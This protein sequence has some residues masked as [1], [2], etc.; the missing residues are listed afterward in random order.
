[1]ILINDTSSGPETFSTATHGQEGNRLSTELSTEIT[2]A[3]ADATQV[4]QVAV[5]APLRRLFDYL[6]PAGRRATE[7]LPG[8]RVRVPLGPRQVVGVVVA[9]AAER[10]GTRSEALTGPAAPL[11][12]AALK[13]ISEVIDA[14]PLL[15]APLMQLLHWTAAY[16]HHPLGEV[17]AAALPRALREG[18][19]ARSPPRSVQYWQLTP[20]GQAASAPLRPSESTPQAGVRGRAQRE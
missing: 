1:M 19:P 4:L 8:M 2:P 6:P 12:P 16:Y 3:S 9:P 15:A 20:E 5:N 14:E 7:L 10:A 18:A 13:N 17:I 11:A